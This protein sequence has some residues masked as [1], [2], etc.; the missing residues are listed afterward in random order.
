V[1]VGMIIGVE[2]EKWLYRPQG[3]YQD[4]WWVLELELLTSDAAGHEI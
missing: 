1:V 3:K 2:M 4:R